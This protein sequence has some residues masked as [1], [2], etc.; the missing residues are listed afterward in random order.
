MEM[1]GAEMMG[2]PRRNAESIVGS[3]DR[4]KGGIRR[5]VVVGREKE[6]GIEV[7]EL[8]A[9]SKGGTKCVLWMGLMRG[10]GAKMGGYIRW[11]SSSEGRLS[12]CLFRVLDEKRDGVE[13]G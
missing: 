6:I 5:V 3:I 4:W 10:T 1:I 9:Q 13:I 7:V 2:S 8:V 12:L 11:T